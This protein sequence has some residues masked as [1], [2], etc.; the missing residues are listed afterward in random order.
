MEINNESDF[1][2]FKDNN[3]KPS[4]ADYKTVES[5]MNEL[6]G[7]EIKPYEYKDDDRFEVEEVKD[8]GGEGYGDDRFS[9]YKIIEKSTG[10]LGY[11]G[12]TVSYN[13]WFGSKWEEK[14]VAE[15]FVSVEIEYGSRDDE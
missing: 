3:L 6:W 10:L 9:C 14:F 11:V 15:P 8:E 13:S 4:T 12:F 5:W 1:V 7:D 2:E